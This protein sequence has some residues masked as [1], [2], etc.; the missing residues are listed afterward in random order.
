MNTILLL[1]KF[2]WTLVYPQWTQRN[3]KDLRFTVYDLRFTVYDLR[4]TLSRHAFLLRLNH[5]IRRKINFIHPLN[6]IRNSSG[7]FLQ[8]RHSEAGGIQHYRIVFR[9]PEKIMQRDRGIGFY[10]CCNRM[11]GNQVFA[12]FEPEGQEFFAV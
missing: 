3:T 7:W 12:M 9:R 2:S 5:I 6:T 11:S 4:F 1:L 10:G 8:I